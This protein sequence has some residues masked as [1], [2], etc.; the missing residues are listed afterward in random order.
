MNFDPSAASPPPGPGVL[1]VGGRLRPGGEAAYARYLAGTRPILAD[2]R[3]EVIAVG[4]GVAVDGAS[5]L[6]PVNAVLRFPSVAAVGAF[7]ADP[8]YAA[9][10]AERDEAYEELHLAVFADR[11]S[12]FAA[13]QAEDDPTSLVV[14]VGRH[15]QAVVARD[16]E[17]VVG[18]YAPGDRTYVF[19]EGPR[20]STRGHERI[21]AGWRA[22]AAASLAVDRVEWLEG[23]VAQV[24]GRLG[25][26]AG[27]VEVVVRVA[28]VE[29]RVRFRG[30]FVMHRDP[31]GE[32][33]IVHEHFSQPAADPYGIG[34]WLPAGGAAQAEP[35]PD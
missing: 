17:A 31:A 10:R 8:R 21:A 27:I 18:R 11:G 7:L 33:R 20:W 4:A 16:V 1:V 30:S 22:F 23:P 3:G 12:R 15:F 2:H 32:W 24:E 34:D 9:I 19:V 25:W 28:G 35:R 29:R 6:W 26:I 5:D 14:A 13:G